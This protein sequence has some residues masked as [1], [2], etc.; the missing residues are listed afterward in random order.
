MIKGKSAFFSIGLIILSIQSVLDVVLFL[1]IYDPDT[2]KLS[3]I[4]KTIL[5]NN[6]FIQLLI[7]SFLI[8]SWLSYF[9]IRENIEKDFM[10]YRQ[11]SINT[12]LNRECNKA[13]QA[14][15]AKTKFLSRVS[16]DMRT[17][18]NGIIGM[19]KIAQKNI[20]NQEQV[21]KRLAK[22]ENISEH[23][24]LLINDVLDMAKIEQDCVEI[25]N[26]PFDLRKVTK[27]CLD[28]I[29]CQ[30]ENRNIEFVNEIRYLNE[31][32]IGDELHLKQILINVLSNAVKF[33]NDNGKI[34]F[35]AIEI[36]VSKYRFIV[37][38]LGIGMSEEFLNKIFEPFS[39][40][41]TVGQ[42]VE[43]KG[44]GLGMAI[45]KNLVDL[46]QGT[47]N[48]ESKQGEGTKITIDL[49]FVPQEKGELIN[50]NEQLLEELAGRK[51][52]LVED[53]FINVEIAKS[54]LDEV[55]IS[56][57]V[58]LNG[59]E[60]I[61]K[62]MASKENEYNAILMDVMMPVLDGIEATKQIRSLDRVDAKYIY[63]I[64]MTANAYIEDKQAV[65]EAGMNE[66]ISKPIDFNHLYNLLLNRK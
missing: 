44:T 14:S 11:K 4:F 60:A 40:E 56:Y 3:E 27:T 58:A 49:C 31:S 19:T 57:D 42:K 13:K 45:V 50:E 47:I 9:L 62:F 28:I 8:F 30:A 63:I 54:M 32:V 55:K 24:L 1:H 16:H 59:Q 20:S 6:V 23:L 36:E 7:F 35:K 48:V 12:K 41:N 26:N 65:L 17:P 52:L 34:I 46:M 38:D 25:V 33:T 22:I 29:E 39:Q 64:A 61:D 37:Q 15:V 51:V 43:L 53:N 21:K 66:H 18:M 5:I 10:I 2:F